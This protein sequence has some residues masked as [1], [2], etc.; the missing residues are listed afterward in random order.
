MYNLPA[1]LVILLA[2]GLALKGVAGW[3]WFLVL[4]FIL[5]VAHDVSSKE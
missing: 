3:G 4:A 5:I 2:A 1:L